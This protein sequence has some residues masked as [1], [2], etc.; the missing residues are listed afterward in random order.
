MVDYSA[1]DDRARDA[2]GVTRRRALGVLGGGAIA[3]LAG[4]VGLLSNGDT[5]LD[6]NPED[7]TPRAPPS[8]SPDEQFSL[9]PTPGTAEFSAP[10]WL[11]DDVFPGP[12]LRVS[13][14]DIVGVSLRSDLP[15]ET[16]VHWHG[17]PVANA[18][19]GV[20]NVTQDPVKSGESFEYQ[21]RAD[22]PGTYF[23]HSHA[24]LQLDRGLAGP[25]IIEEDDPH[26]TVDDDHVVVLD[27][28]LGQEPRSPSDG[29]TPG[30]F[31]MGGGRMGGMMADYRPP[32]AA[33]VMNGRGPRNPPT[34]EVTEG[35]RVRFRFVNAS[36]ATTF[37]VRTGGHAV[38]VSHADGQPV[39]PVSV[40]SFVFGPGERY[41]VVLTADNPGTWELQATPVRGRES[42]ARGVLQYAGE[43]EG[44]TP[45]APE[46]G[47]RTLQYGD[48]RAVD[49]LDGIDGS[50]DRTFDLTLSPGGDEYSWAIDGQVYPDADP[51]D[52][53]EGDHVRI[54]MQNQ[55]PVP[56]PMHLH[57]HFF[58]VGD[59]IKD[60]VV[61]PG[62]MG[63]VTIDIH[64]DNPGN[65]LFHCHNLYHLEAGMARILRYV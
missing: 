5:T 56:H 1:V 28:Y 40:D 3:S 52:V 29:D 34:F 44:Q 24:G 59:T 43:R 2:G 53:R 38:E 42:A 17:L 32:Y 46:S 14:G 50:P 61:V 7:V 6:G 41:D 63:E 10:T 4:C 48:L 25:L 21:F 9:N 18:M 57:G 13:E 16:T 45:T 30:D 11:Y 20:P 26:V 35:E 27:D 47:G 55:S 12:E 19:D 49:S 8:G 54:R 22:Q 64:A 65:W 23:Y 60:T 36:S 39:D 51:L 33:M 15:A 58:E 31:G 37:R 62:R